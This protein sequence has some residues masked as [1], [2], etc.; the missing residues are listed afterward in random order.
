M[1]DFWIELDGFFYET[2]INFA[3]P[4]PGVGGLVGCLQNQGVGAR[5]A[6]LHILLVGF[7]NTLL[8]VL[9]LDMVCDCHLWEGVI[10]S[11]WVKDTIKHFP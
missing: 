7:S 10:N 8:V 3:G 9:I 11:S 4:N 2:K 5:I 1:K 6:F